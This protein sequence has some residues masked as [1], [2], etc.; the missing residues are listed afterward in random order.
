M[1]DKLRQVVIVF[2][3]Q[4]LYLLNLLLKIAIIVAF[5]VASLVVIDSFPIRNR[6]LLNITLMNLEL[7]I[8]IQAQFFIYQLDFLFQSFDVVDICFFYLASSSV[9]YGILQ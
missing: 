9:F 7:S 4:S 5:E 1:I 3:L 2:L 6:L 8:L